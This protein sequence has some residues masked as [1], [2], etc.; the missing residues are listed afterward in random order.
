M[1]LTSAYAGCLLWAPVGPSDRSDPYL[2]VTCPTML[3]VECTSKSGD[4]FFIRVSSHRLRW[5]GDH[6]VLRPMAR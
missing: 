3:H 6:N 4:L 2:T 1:S 5:T